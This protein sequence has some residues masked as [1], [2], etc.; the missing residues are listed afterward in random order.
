MPKSAQNANLSLQ[1]VPLNTPDAYPFI[2]AAIL[3]IRASGVRHEVQPFSTV[4][5]GELERLL[6]I[7]LAAKNAALE[8]GA[9]ELLLNI[10]IHLKK[11]GDVWLEDKTRKWEEK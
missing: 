5:E 2:D 6:E 10:Q 4:M 3:A 11:E 8:A 9:E 1:V 7:V